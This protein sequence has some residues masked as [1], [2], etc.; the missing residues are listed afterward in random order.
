[1]SVLLL[2]LPPLLLKSTDRCSISLT[3]LSIHCL[4]DGVSHGS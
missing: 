4:L 2:L 3:Y 1:M